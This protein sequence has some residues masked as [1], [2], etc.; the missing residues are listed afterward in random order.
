MSD[1]CLFDVNN[2]IHLFISIRWLG[3]FG[4][5]KLSLAG[6]FSAGLTRH[7]FRPGAAAGVGVSYKSDWCGSELWWPCGGWGGGQMSASQQWALNNRFRFHPM[8]IHDFFV[9]FCLGVVH[10]VHVFFQLGVKAAT[11]GLVAAWTIFFYSSYVGTSTRDLVWR[12]EF[13]DV[14]SCQSCRMRRLHGQTSIQRIIRQVF[15]SFQWFGKREC[16]KCVHPGQR[17]I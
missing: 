4:A 14:K 3:H 8:T 2:G 9:Q 11:M 1:W 12:R 6:C 16:V 17:Y 15:G 7:V 5:N 13:H 10:D